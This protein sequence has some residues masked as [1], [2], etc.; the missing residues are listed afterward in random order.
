[1]VRFSTMISVLLV[2]TPM[3]AQQSAVPRSADELTHA[4]AQRLAAEAASPVDLLPRFTYLI[5]NHVRSSVHGQVQDDHTDTLER[6]FIGGKPYFRLL[7][8]DGKPLSG[9]DLKHETE[10]Y[11]QTVRERT[12][13]RPAPQPAKAE[14]DHLQDLPI[15][16]LDAEFSHKITGA[17]TINGH[18][19]VVLDLSPL[20]PEAPSK[21]QRRIR[22]TIDPESLSVINLSI[23]YLAS[24]N[25]FSK[26]TMV[27]SRKVY[28]DGVLVP[29][30]WSAETLVGTTTD[31][32]LIDWHSLSTSTFSEYKRV[33][34][35]DTVL[36]PGTK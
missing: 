29:A 24:S 27:E 1:M 15:D 30:F 14:N 10:R 11:D 17:E 34:T 32:S 36:S 13:S 12:S 7:E 33:A 16:Q 28:F 3:L 4:W 5:H 26:G 21:L 2:T 25:G 9:R 8:K 19:F 6:I 20:K 35:P 31:N 23:E 22:V 18:L